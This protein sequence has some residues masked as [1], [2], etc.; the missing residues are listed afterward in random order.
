MGE[1]SPPVHFVYNENF[2]K[3]KDLR[4]EY[5]INLIFFE[6]MRLEKYTYEFR[7]FGQGTK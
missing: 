3:I 2:V 5:T 6:D 7:E 1:A 4:L